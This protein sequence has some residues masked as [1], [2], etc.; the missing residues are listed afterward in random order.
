MEI[1][2]S[3]KQFFDSIIELIRLSSD[4]IIFSALYFGTKYEHECLILQE[5]ESAL[6]SKPNMKVSMIFDYSR[7]TRPGNNTLFTLMQKKAIY[8]DRFFVYLYRMPQLDDLKV[9]PPSPLD[10]VLSVYHC[11]YLVFDENVILT[12]ANLSE[13]YFTRR[14]DRYFL[15]KNS[16]ILSSALARFFDM[17][18]K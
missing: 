10:E 11:K 2:L 16:Q 5:I 17:T 8:K 13:E 9:T 4:R 3:P 14:Q 1:L 7:A 15:L 6:L 12:G 18:S